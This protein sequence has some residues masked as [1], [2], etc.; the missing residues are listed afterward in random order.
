V[1]VDADGLLRW[2]RTGQLVD[3]TAGHWKDAGNGGGIVP[4]LGPD[5]TNLARRTSFESLS[6]ISSSD[7]LEYDPESAAMHYA[8]NGKKNN[9]VSRNI[10]RNLTMKGVVER[11]LRKTVRRNTWIYAADK[12]FNIFI[13]IKEPGTF[14]H[15]SL[16]AGGLVSSAGL[17]TVKRGVIHTLSP[18]SGH[19]RTS[20]ANFH[21][22]TKIL[23]ER[24]VDMHKVKYS[25][26]E[27]ALW[28]IE[29]IKKTKKKKAE[30]VDSGKAK[31]ENVLEKASNTFSP[32]AMSYDKLENQTSKEDGSR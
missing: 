9:W 8:S 14:Q 24:G 29:K 1:K 4:I 32:S 15:S 19:Y 23:A 5:K 10:R 18:L 25:K 16:L 3:S 13:G 28:G 7:D 30:I 17:I 31:V 6:S 22:F 27:A 21:Q 2:H 12:N 26:A 11:L 20:I